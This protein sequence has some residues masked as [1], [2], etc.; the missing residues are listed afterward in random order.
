MELSFSLTEQSAVR[1]SKRQ[2]TPFEIHTVKFTGAEIK[3]VGKENKYKILALNFEN[4]TGIA[5]MS[6]FWPTEADTVRPV[7][8]TKDGHEYERASR[9]ENTKA[10]IAQTLQVLNPEGYAKF[11]AVSSKFK[12]FDDM[13]NAFVKVVNAAKDKETNVKFTGYVNKQG[14]TQLS[15]PTIVGINKQGESFI[16][17]NYIGDVVLSNYEMQKAKEFNAPKPTP[18]DTDGSLDAPQDETSF[19]LEDLGL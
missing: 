12:S 3:E 16:S 14:Y 1:T 7:A 9:W 8:T 4:E 18:M 13:A 5:S 17:D 11:Q 6:I 10:V 19:D 15:F 2:L